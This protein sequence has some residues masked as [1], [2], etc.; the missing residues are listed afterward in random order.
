MVSSLN[1]WRIPSVESSL[2]NRI[3][4]VSDSTCQEIQYNHVFITNLHLYRCV[5]NERK[6][7][8]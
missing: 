6:L 7:E 4:D 5:N 8:L 2:Q 3:I 1:A